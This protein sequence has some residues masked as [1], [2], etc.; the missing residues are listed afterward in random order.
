MKNQN[1]RVRYDPADEPRRQM[2]IDGKPLYEFGRTLSKLELNQ[3]IE[4]Y[5]EDPKWEIDGVPMKSMLFGKGNLL[6]LLLQPECHGL[7]IFFGKN[8]DGDPALI[9]VGTHKDGA[10]IL[11]YTLAED[12][13][14][15]CPTRCNE[16]T[17]G[18]F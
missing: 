8:E 2:V 13:G 18:P 17:E 12:G 9:L 4:R 11:K 6:R 1:D 5:K 10:N 7:R 3:F 14:Y 16:D 15:L